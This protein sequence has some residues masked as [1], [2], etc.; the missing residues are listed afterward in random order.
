MEHSGSS[1]LLPEGLEHLPQGQGR[2][3]P[4]ARGKGTEAGHPS[5]SHSPALW[6]PIAGSCTLV[7]RQ[8][9]STG[10]RPKPQTPPILW[11]QSLTSSC[12]RA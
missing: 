5:S 2:A 7:L 8:P 3:W 6:A 12:K 11:D 1:G 4:P 9:A 10:V